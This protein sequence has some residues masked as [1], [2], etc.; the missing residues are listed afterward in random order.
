MNLLHF[1][2]WVATKFGFKLPALREMLDIATSVITSMSA[3]SVSMSQLLLQ[4]APLL[5]YNS[6]TDYIKSHIGLSVV[7]NLLYSRVS[8]LCYSMVA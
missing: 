3:R 5:A 8:S 4:C 6:S 1:P 7:L 2:L